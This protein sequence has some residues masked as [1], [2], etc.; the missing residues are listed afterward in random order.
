[1][2]D[3]NPLIMGR[4]AAFAP[5]AVYTGFSMRLVL[6]NRCS[7]TAVEVLFQM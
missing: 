3:L 1:M 6:K 4:E 7:T 2:S 5:Q